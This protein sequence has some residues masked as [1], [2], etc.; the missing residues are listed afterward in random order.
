[1]R[2]LEQLLLQRLELLVRHAV[3]VRLVALAVLSCQLPRDKTATH[4]LALLELGVAVLCI[5]DKRF[6]AEL[7]LSA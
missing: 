6:E 2:V 5:G 4:L 7:L 1:M 3:R